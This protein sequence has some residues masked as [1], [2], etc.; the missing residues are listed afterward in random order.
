MMH[1][2]SP[3]RRARAEADLRQ[4]R[5]RTDRTHEIA[6]KAFGAEHLQAVAFAG[7]DGDDAAHASGLH[8]IAVRR[9]HQREQA[10]GFAAFDAGTDHEHVERLLAGGRLLDQS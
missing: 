6:G 2:G 5:R 8:R 10:S 9:A 4:Q 3:G 7:L 1:A